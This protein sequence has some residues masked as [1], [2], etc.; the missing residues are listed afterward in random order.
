[1]V[2]NYGTGGD[3]KNRGRRTEDEPAPT[4]TSKAGRNKWT[5]N[6]AV[7]GDTSWSETR[8]SPT[9][10]GSFAPDVVASPGWRKAGD[11]PR[12]SQPGSIRVT[13]Q[14]AATLQTFPPD[15]P[16]QGPKGKQF[17]AVGNAI[18]PML[19]RAVLSR[20]AL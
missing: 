2:S 12:Q 16:F 13:V 6:A 11:G 18:P 4:V 20:A 5:P 14:E 7:P 1:M 15:Y 19:A 9:I 3:P 17:E 10:V 8:P